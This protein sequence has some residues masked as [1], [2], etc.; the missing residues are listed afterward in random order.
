MN[1][2]QVFDEETKN[3]LVKNKFNIVNICSL[4]NG[5]MWTFEN[6]PELFSKLNFSKNKYKLTN[7]FNF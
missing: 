1:F 3:V 6:R 7:R 5:T 4:N 2:I